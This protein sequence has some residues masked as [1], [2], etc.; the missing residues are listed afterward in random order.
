MTLFWIIF[1]LFWVHEA[2]DFMYPEIRERR[3]YERTVKDFKFGK[4]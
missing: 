4:R 1:I 2:L 3:I